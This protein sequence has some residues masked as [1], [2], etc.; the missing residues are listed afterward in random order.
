MVERQDIHGIAEATEHLVGKHRRSDHIAIS[1]VA[2]AAGV[3]P[4]SLRVVVFNS[5]G[6][7]VTNL[8]GGHVDVIASPAASV[9]GHAQ[10]GKLRVLAISAKKRLPGPLSNVPTW[11]EQ[12]FPVISGN[13]RNI[14]GPKG[15]S[16]EQVRYWDVAFATLTQQDEW[17][18]EAD[19]RMLENA[20]F[21]SAQTREA[22]D[23]L[24]KELREILGQLGLAQQ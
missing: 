17:K 1:Q 10:A 23:S 2:R 14:V 22:M 3:D 6:Q 9:A 12:G 5:S 21:T 24:Y 15:M 13:V 7:V 4:K 19:K 20:H 18:K 16:D 8:L 11:T